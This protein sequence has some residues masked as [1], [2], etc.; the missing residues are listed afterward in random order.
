MTDTTDE[1]RADDDYERVK[2][3]CSLLI[4]HFDAVQIFASR[5]TGTDE[6]T[7]GIHH[8][9]GNWYTRRGQVEDWRVKQD[10]GAR[11]ERRGDG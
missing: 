6:G 1:Q 7:L 4:E 11:I 3:A 8:G 9:A 10:E 2:R 5:D